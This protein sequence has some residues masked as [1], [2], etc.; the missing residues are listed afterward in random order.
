MARPVLPIGLNLGTIGVTLDWWIESSRRAEDAGFASVLA[1]DHF[2]SR[3]RLGDSVLECW[4]TA[5][6]AAQATT[7]INVGSFVTNVM[8]RHPAVLARIVGT[9]TQLTD[10]RIELGIGIGG[11]PAE[12]VAYGIDFPDRPERAEHLVEALDVLRLLL[13]GG[14]ADYT[15]DRYRLGAAHAFPVPTV[16]PRITVSGPKP[17]GTRLATRHADAWTCFAHQYEGLRPVF[18]TALA[19]A[20]RERREVAV[21][22]GIEVE[23]IVEGDLAPTAAGWADRDV[24]ELVIHDVRGDRF[25][26]VLAAMPA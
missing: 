5:A 6:A 3:G 21:L 17:A 7:T 9:V 20:G 18:D 12:H 25:D 2:V 15:G 22:V 26:E 1:W 19:D 23:D 8:N 16:A 10:A 4:T 13:A 14:P 11:H 24:D